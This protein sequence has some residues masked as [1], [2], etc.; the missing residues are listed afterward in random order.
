MLSA[1]V[2]KAKQ[3][4][5]IWKNNGEGHL[6]GQVD[7]CV[8]LTPQGLHCPPYT[9]PMAMILPSSSW[10]TSRVLPWDAPDPISSPALSHSPPVLRGPGACGQLP[11]TYYVKPSS[12]TL[13]WE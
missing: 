6:V 1:R 13:P 12:S 8:V 9:Q 7:P 3:T 11:L 4:D 10:T 5:V 2:H